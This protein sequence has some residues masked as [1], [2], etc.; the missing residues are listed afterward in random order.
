MPSLNSLLHGRARGGNPLYLD[1]R[2]KRYILAALAPR[3]SEI[4]WTIA[5]DGPA[6]Q[7]WDGYDRRIS[8]PWRDQAI[9]QTA[10]YSTMP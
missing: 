3:P 5:I 7:A 6:R 10:N 2:P 1:I 9:H 4:G 8:I